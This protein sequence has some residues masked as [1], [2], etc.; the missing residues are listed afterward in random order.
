MPHN[1]TI[2]LGRILG[3]SLTERKRVE[4]ELQESQNQLAGII[5]SAMDAIISIDEAQR[6]VLFNTAAKRCLAVLLTGPSGSRSTASFR[7]DSG[8]P[9]GSISNAL[10]RLA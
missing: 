9:T 1:V 10:A 5:A 6:I 7:N 2:K 3:M 8:Q 4:K